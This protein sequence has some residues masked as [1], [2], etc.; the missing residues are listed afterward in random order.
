M[1]GDS[2]VYTN[3]NNRRS[4][5]PS[6]HHQSESSDCSSA[7]DATVT[8]ST[9]SS[10]E[11][12]AIVRVLAAVL[13]RLTQ[14]N[15]QQHTQS[16]SQQQQEITKFHALKPPQ[17]SVLAYL[18]RIYKYANCSSE[19]FVLAL[20]YIDRLIS[21]NNFLLTD[22]NVHRVLITA[23]MLAA[24]FF[25]DAY[26]NNAYYAKVGGIAVSELNVLEVEFLFRI[27]FELHCASDVYVQYHGE[28]VHHA[29]QQQQQQT[30]S[31]IPLAMAQCT[32]EVPHGLAAATAAATG[33]SSSHHPTNHHHHH[34]N[35][36][37]TGVL[38]GMN[39]NAVGMYANATSL[40]QPS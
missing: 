14:T 25:D 22:L 34:H 19:C 31:S 7:A 5:H 23:V 39:H 38:H 28:L 15:T 26:Y 13:E 9:V 12:A 3:S 10:S 36:N 30:T 1:E 20:I 21:K 24:K 27:H 11:G 35:V 18:E 17:I 8:V 32:Y 37:N 2:Q 6:G 16:S 40:H 4:M 29:L 33:T